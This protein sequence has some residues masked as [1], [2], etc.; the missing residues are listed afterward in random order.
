VPSD[1]YLL[2][3][4]PAALALREA[5][6]RFDG[7]QPRTVAHV[8]REKS[9]LRSF[10]ETIS[11]KIERQSLPSLLREKTDLRSLTETLSEEIER[12]SLPSLLREKTDLRSITKTISEE[13][14][15]PSISRELAEMR[16]SRIASHHPI[17]SA[18][19]LAPLIR[20]S[21]KRMKMSQ[22]QFADACGV[23]RRFLSE[24]E[25]GKASLEFD[26]VLA[27]A[28]GAGIDL[29]AKPRRPL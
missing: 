9:D 4:D 17:T 13:L 8:L 24:L 26:K 15:H 6:A 14:Q 20:A 27:C 19:D 12:Q 23:G 16:K 10:A 28:L 18:A 25:N 21:R 3:N 11:E 22:Q 29:S 7:R 1:K 5:R 2:P